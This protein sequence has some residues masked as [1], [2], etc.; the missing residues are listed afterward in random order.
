MGQYN[1]VCF[2]LSLS[3]K[4][5]TGTKRETNREEKKYIYIL[6]TAPLDL[7]GLIIQ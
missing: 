4:L 5:H 7:V 2:L 3:I 6:N 1:K